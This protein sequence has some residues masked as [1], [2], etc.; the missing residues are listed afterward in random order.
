MGRVLVTTD[1]LRPGDAVDQLLRGHGHEVVHR[2]H[3][4]P[5]TAEELAEIFAGVDAALVASEPITDTSLAISPRLRVVARSGVGYDSVDVEAATRL[6]I[7]VANTPGANSTAVAEM[8][9]AMLLLCAR[10]LPETID[11]VRIGGWPRHDT[12]EL[13]GATLGIV[14]FG[15][16]GRAVARLAGAFGMTVLVHSRNPDDTAAVTFVGLNELLT[17]SDYV[18]LHAKLDD[19]TRDL[20]DSRALRLMKPSAFLV[21]TARGALVDE[22]ALGD[23]VRSGTIAGAAL[24]VLRHE[25]MRPDDPLRDVA[26]IVVLSHLAGQTAQAR[27]NAGLAA[28]R[29]VVAVLAGEQPVEVVNPEVFAMAAG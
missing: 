3:R 27:A 8:T 22:V 20:I 10:R 4:G 5:R 16:S 14:G 17:R 2:P 9:I 18:S 29:T 28:A 15:A 25:P 11:G 24:D 6:G 21:N 1:Y 13:R 12:H 23:A 26:G 19:T 7:A